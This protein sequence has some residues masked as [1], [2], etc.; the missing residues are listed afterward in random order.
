MERQPDKNLTR[1]ER[2]ISRRLETAI[3]AVEALAD[4]VNA[5]AQQARKLGRTADEKRARRMYVWIM[6]GLTQTRNERG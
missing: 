4:N 6:E 1:Q 2:E 5:I 3:L